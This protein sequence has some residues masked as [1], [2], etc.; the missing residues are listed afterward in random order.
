MS[1]AITFGDAKKN[2]YLKYGN[3]EMAAD[4]GL[5]V[6]IPAKITT[7]TFNQQ[8]ADDADIDI[9]LN[10]VVVETLTIVDEEHTFFVDIDVLQGDLLNAV[11]TV[12]K[13]LKKSTMTL[14]FDE[15][16]FIDA[17][18][19]GIAYG[20][21]D[22]AWTEVLEPPAPPVNNGIQIGDHVDISMVTGLLIDYVVLYVP[23]P[24]E[25]Y[26]VVAPADTPL[27]ITEVGPSIISIV[28]RL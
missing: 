14:F 16:A 21:K 10:G 1:Y 17:P 6:P 12:N 20:R 13:D 23:Q 2:K 27:I 3:Q 19:D 28:K 5:I 25:V 11:N 24:E 15:R 8:N 4:R 18:F 26:W 7:I 9:Q 22:G